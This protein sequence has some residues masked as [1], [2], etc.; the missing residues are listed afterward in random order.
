VAQQVPGQVWPGEA[1]ADAKPPDVQFAASASQLLEIDE[2][3]VALYDRTAANH[4]P[5]ISA[6]PAAFFG[7]P[8]G[9]N[10][11]D[12]RLTF[13][14]ASGR[15]FASAV[16]WFL[17]PP[18]SP[19]S[20]T[21]TVLVSVSQGTDAGQGW[22]VYQVA[23][24]SSLLCDQPRL[25]LASDKVVVVC[26][27]RMATSALPT[28]QFVNEA[29]WAL[30]KE[31]AVAGSPAREVYVELAG[32]FGVVPALSPGPAS[33]EYLAY[34]D[35]DPFALV[36][37]QAGPTLGVLAMTGVPGGPPVQFTESHPAVTAT[38]APPGAVQQGTTRL[39]D[40]GDD[41]LQNAVWQNGV[42]WTSGNDACV[43][44]QDTSFRSC[45]HLVQVSTSG[46]SPVIT[47]SFD[48]G[49]AKS[50]LYFPAL[51]VDA[52]GDLFCVYNSSSAVRTI[53]LNLA[54]QAVEGP[55][56]GLNGAISLVTSSAAYAG[57]WGHYAGAATD[58]DGMHVWLAG[59]Y[60]VD[61]SHWVPQA[62]EVAEAPVL[63]SVTPGS[64]P[65]TGGQQVTITG[66]H[67]QPG[68]QVKF[69]GQQAAGVTVVSDHQIIAVSPAAHPGTVGVHVVNP[70][71]IASQPAGGL[72]YSFT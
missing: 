22:N 65:G 16:A 54:D 12:P 58:P 60:P 6:T 30:N 49:Q 37:D 44:A 15:W 27:N 45:L 48:F 26:D 19:P 70:D 62:R 14:N 38:N 55:A 34:N 2:D 24:S 8:P 35:A 33:V 32:R 17:N 23:T 43:P 41:R 40:T 4:V 46:A 63:T 56:G 57:A 47:Q 72:P 20:Y 50:Y 11:S 69:G 36:Q 7:I 13:D 25:G 28:S 29:A 71:G 9:W 66:S 21:S 31:D 10:L 3:H 53:G 42:L 5:S 18:P 52:Q 61:S 1:S 67:F 39:V 68:V 59:A 51:A 64:G